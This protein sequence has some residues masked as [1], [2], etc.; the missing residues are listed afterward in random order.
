MAGPEL[1]K[2]GKYLLESVRL[3]F[4]GKTLILGENSE[5]DVDGITTKPAFGGLDYR[6][7]LPRTEFTPYHDAGMRGAND[8]VLR[9][10]VRQT[11]TTRAK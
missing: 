1:G 10:I 7:S 2:L 9:A 5:V 8:I 3:M 11:G 6:W 4:V